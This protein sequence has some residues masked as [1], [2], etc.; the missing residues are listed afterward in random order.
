MEQPRRFGFGAM[1]IGLAL[2]AAGAWGAQTYLLPQ[3]QGAASVED[4]RFAELQR[5]LTESDSR[6]MRLVNARVAEREE[7]EQQLAARDEQIAEFEK[8]TKV[9][10]DRIV[11]LREGRQPVED[12]RNDRI[13]QLEGMVQQSVAQRQAL[14]AEVARVSAERDQAAEAVTAL[15]QQ[16]A[17]G[18]QNAGATEDLERRATEAEAQLTE[19]SR[20]RDLA[21]KTVA[22]LR[23]RLAADSAAGGDAAAERDRLVEALRIAERDAENAKAAAADLRSRVSGLEAQLA[24]A[25][26]DAGDSQQDQ[27]QQAMLIAAQ[28]ERDAAKREL[29]ALRQQIAEASGGQAAGAQAAGDQ[30]DQAAL[31]LNILTGAGGADDAP[32]APGSGG[33]DE[34]MRLAGPYLPQSLIQR[35]KIRKGLEDGGTARQVVTDVLTI[36]YEK[37]DDLIEAL[38]AGLPSDRCGS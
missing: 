26:S 32:L 25:G 37:F 38:C 22:D 4:A 6:A 9:L 18:R 28:R 12:E 30:S 24:E 14:E 33:V 31:G 3:I 13:R 2:G 15:R 34:A 10:Q 16:A 36:T 23:E 29:E 11:A 35:D 17:E 20:E 8:Q 1:I 21:M 5:Q 19:V 27:V 7:H